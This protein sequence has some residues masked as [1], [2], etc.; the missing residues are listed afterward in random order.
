MITRPLLLKIS[1]LCYIINSALP[2][3][4]Q[5][6]SA[7]DTAPGVN[8]QATAPEAT[9]TPVPA[10][11]IPGGT[12]LLSNG[13]FSLATLDRAWPDDWAK[14]ESGIAWK[15]DGAKHFLSFVSQHPDQQVELER[16]IDIPAGV[17]AVEFSARYRVAG[18]KNGYSGGYD[19]RT[20][21]LFL[22]ASSKPVGAAP[23]VIF[24]SG[25]K[26]WTTITE[27]F[28]VRKGAVKFLINPCLFRVKA[29]TL[30]IAEI[31]V[32][33]IGEP[34]ASKV[35]AEDAAAA[36]KKAAEQ[37]T[38]LERE[39]ALPSKSPELKV[40]GN[41]LVTADGKTV[42]LQ[43]MNVCGLEWLPEG[44]NPV[45]SV[46]VAID[47][48]KASVI[49][50]PVM[51]SF[52]FGRGKG[53]FVSNDQEAY[54]AIVDQAIKVAAGKGAYIVL[55]LHRYL[56]PDDR[57]VEFWKDAAARYKNNPA[58][59]FDIMNEPHD[60][61]W[62]IWRNGGELV[63]KGKDARTI[64]S[65]GMQGLVDAVRGTGAKN[66]IVAGGLGYAFDLTGIVKGYA[67]DDKG[68]NGIMYATHFYNWHKGWA[69][70]FMEVA[71]R[72]PILV[73]ECGADP[74]KMNFIPAKDQEDPYT[75]APDAIG[76]IQKNHLNWT[77]WCL[78]TRATPNMLLDFDYYTPTPFWGAF[79]KDALAGRQYQMKRER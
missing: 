39:A 72:Y 69:K 10:A 38:I 56:T 60:T 42:W 4:A 76:F 46:H 43:G 23:P 55:D 62:D 9:P 20:N 63:T 67:L 33:T 49:R 58:V 8:P 61:T 28:A 30:D 75:W 52:W 32:T 54:R 1:L 15:Q 31:H 44:N 24:S 17:A 41:K 11:G 64:Q 47:D 65:V 19:A 71:A 77:A 26:Q 29:G 21:I 13:D 57:C 25:A 73:G 50:L 3:Y 27:R 36:E 68:G 6:T 16:V 59:L 12:S 40:S 7:L 18:L 66:I 14:G 37:K 74:H 35:V 5:N 53:K 51:D 70:H 34:D 22:D 79:V 2:L 45:W 78:H 48:W